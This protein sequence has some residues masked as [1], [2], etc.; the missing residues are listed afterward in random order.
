MNS[1]EIE[2]Y[3]HGTSLLGRYRTSLVQPLSARRF[4]VL[5][6]AVA[7][8]RAFRVAT[9]SRKALVLRGV[10]IRVEPH[11]T[12]GDGRSGRRPLRGWHQLCRKHGARVFGGD[13]SVAGEAQ[14]PRRLLAHHG[15]GGLRCGHGGRGTPLAITA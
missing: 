10:T 9:N 13:L 12:S 15:D 11:V 14:P 1:V 8:L 3:G 2:S 5:R 6:W 4:G 7:M